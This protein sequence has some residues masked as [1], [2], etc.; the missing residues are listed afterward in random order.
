V[1]FIE[2]FKIAVGSL[3]VNKLRSALTMLGMIIGVGAVIV[4]MS[5]G[6]GLQNYIT[7]TF[8]EMGSNLLCHCQ[9]Y[10]G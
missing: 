6:Q 8:E 7:S 1:K 3:L 2:F 10:Y 4:L 5:V 9:S